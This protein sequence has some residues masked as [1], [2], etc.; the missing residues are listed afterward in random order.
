MI[1]SKK[2]DNCAN[3]FSI[4]EITSKNFITHKCD[5]CGHIE[6]IQIS[7][8]QK[9]LTELGKLENTLNKIDKNETM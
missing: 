9:L 3:T 2:C 7:K 4:T 6:K 5:K 8:M 1:I